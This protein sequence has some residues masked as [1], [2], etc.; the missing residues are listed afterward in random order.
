[1]SQDVEPLRGAVVLAAVQGLLRSV[2]IRWQQ[3]CGQAPH[4]RSEDRLVLEQQILPA[5]AREPGITRVL[6]SGCAVY[7]QQY[8]AQFAA[9]EY[10]TID[11]SRRQRRYG[12]RRHIVDTLQHLALHVPRGYFDLV[13][14]NG[15]LGWGVDTQEEADAAFAACYAALREGGYLLLGWNDVFPRNRVSPDE[16]RSLAQFERV[17]FGPFAARLRVA[18]SHRHVFDFYR[19]LSTIRGKSGALLHQEFPA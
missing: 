5:Y 2:S 11:R 18:S 7:T 1:M 10:W 19:K 13:V 17:P 12:A 3:V 4:L 9:A 15:I 14:C 8:E 16:L 6:F